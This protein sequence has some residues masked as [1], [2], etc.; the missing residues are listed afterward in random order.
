MLEGD[1]QKKR[2]PN[3]EDQRSMQCQDVDRERDPADPAP[4]P[5]LEAG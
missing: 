5:T 2:L 3:G 4:V 1:R